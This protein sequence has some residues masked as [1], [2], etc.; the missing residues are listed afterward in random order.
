MDL[1]KSKHSNPMEIHYLVIIIFA[2]LFCPRMLR[3]FGRLYSKNKTKCK[4]SKINAFNLVR[5]KIYLKPI[6]WLCKFLPSYFLVL[7]E[8]S[9]NLA[10]LFCIF[11]LV[12]LHNTLFTIFS[13]A[14]VHDEQPS[15]TIK[16]LNSRKRINIE[17]LNIFQNISE[18]A[19][20]NQLKQI[21]WI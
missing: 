16:C 17:N 15:P 11:W 2:A 5:I 4:N 10:P 9:Q 19:G 8:Q 1:S 18:I 7:P 3:T 21:N 13:H 12:F 6:I 20:K 14:F